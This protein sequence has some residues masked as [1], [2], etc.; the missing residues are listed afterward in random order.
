MLT[1]ADHQHP[2][3]KDAS[4]SSTR[5]FPPGVLVVGPG[6]PGCPG[7]PG[8]PTGCVAD[9]CW[10]E[11]IPL[12][13]DAILICFRAVVKP[14]LCYCVIGC[15][16]SPACKRLSLLCERD[17]VGRLQSLYFHIVV[18]IEGQ[19]IT[20]TLGF[21]VVAASLMLA[22]STVSTVLWD[23]ICNGVKKKRRA[24]VHFN[25]RHGPLCKPDVA[26]WCPGAET[27]NVTKA[28]GVPETDS[29]TEDDGFKAPTSSV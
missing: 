13:E 24:Y 10:P 12:M 23:G 14:D 3:S 7:P 1:E 29:I 17:L 6:K 15:T 22:S 26:C 11:N 27:L 5:V 25:L 20:L 16:Q 19:E 28:L 8:P 2:T 21:A 9:G 4:S 18:R